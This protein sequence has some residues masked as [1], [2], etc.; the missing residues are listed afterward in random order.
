MTSRLK[1]VFKPV[2]GC[3][4]PAAPLLVLLLASLLAS[5][6]P[7]RAQGLDSSSI[8]DAR[9]ALRKKDRTRL[10]A[11]RNAAVD[12]NHP[13]AMWPDYWEL[14]NRIG[15]VQQAEISGFSARW[16]GTYVEDRLRNDWLLELGKRRDWVNFAAEF[17]R[18]RMNDDREVT[19]YALLTEHL[20]GKDVRDAARDAWLAQREAD[21]G[22]VLLATTLREAKLFTPAD[23]WRKAR[24][25]IDANRPRA[26]RQAVEVVGPAASVSFG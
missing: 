2:Y 14:G 16:G 10:A 7:A 13:L 17:P 24:L 9:D 26:A 18:F 20:A 15:D 21:D 22:C 19:C 11:L 12:A 4:A 23:G 1:T 5:A 3:T 25:S 6:Q 8:V